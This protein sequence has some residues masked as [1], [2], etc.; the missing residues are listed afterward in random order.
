MDS[1]RRR[2]RRLSVKRKLTAIGVISSMTSLVFAC[3][4]LVLVDV[5]LERARVMRDITTITDV[6]AM[7]SAAAIAFADAEAATGTLSALRVNPHVVAAALRLPDGRVVGR[8]ARGSSVEP[9]SLLGTLHLSRPVVFR[10]ETVGT[11]AVEADY[12]E[13]QGRIE[14]YL[15]I[16][17]VASVGAFLIAVTLSSRLQGLISTPLAD[18]TAAARRVIADRKYDGRVTQTSHDE[19]GELISGFNEML[20]EIQTRDRKLLHHQAELER[21]VE[22]RTAELRATNSD[23]AAARDRAMEASRAKSEFLANMSHEIRTPM[24]GIIGM[25]ELAL[26]TDLSTQQRDYLTTVK[27]SAGSLLTIL[28]DILD[29][30][31]SESQKLELEAIPFSLRDVVGRMLTPIAARADQKGLE[32]LCDINAN[33]PEAVVGDPIR[34]QQILGNLLG[35]AVK[36]TDRGYIVLEVRQDARIDGRSLLHFSITDTGIGI[37]ADKHGLI[38]EPF[39]QADGSTTRR[40]GGTGLGLTISATLVRKMAGQIWVE[41]TPGEGSTFHFT[42]D[43]E[44]AAPALPN[45]LPEPLLADLRVLIVDD[46]PVNRKILLGQFGRWHTR[47]V[48]VASGYEALTA[49]ARAVR[50]ADPFRLV[51]LDVNMPGLDGFDVAERVQSMPELGSPSIV[52]LSSSGQHG[53]S[54]RC[55]ELGIAAYL[56]KPVQSAEL[57]DAICRVLSHPMT[58]CDAPPSTPRA[59]ERA[60]LP[61]RVLLVEDNLINQ[62]VAVGLLARRGHQAIVAENGVHALA[63]LER[64]SFDVILMDLQMPEMGGIEA[65]RLIRAREATTGSRTRIVAMT[66]HAMSGDRERCLAAGMDGYISKPIEPDEFYATLEQPV[67]LKVADRIPADIPS[68]SFDLAGFKKRLGDDLDLVRRVLDAVVED[69]PPQLL[70]LQAAVTNRDAAAIRAAAHALKGAAGNLSATRLFEA[71]KAMEQCG[72]DA[73]LAEADA[74]WQRVSAEAELVLEAVRAA[75]SAALT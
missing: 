10:G 6:A 61:L 11:I 37:P 57:H 17:G 70:A 47:P 59:V 54:P 60:A 41:S 2:L 40:F 3:I 4:V 67:P 52:M 20:D 43:F 64:D 44:I 68:A 53:D 62:Q 24:N 56:T 55:H 32:V 75:Q 69:C 26:D 23:L 25:T 5:S 33:V 8:Y 49:L 27:A 36:F 31:K 42:A 28:N 65:T 45:P 74:A 14:Q 34:L 48:A 21:T 46:N 38:F 19:I 73:R 71:L 66:A 7:N 39:S 13:V 50:G 18:L 29:F 35:N 63:E 9:A 16:L 15:G 51:V 58:A 1:L 12:D 72:T 30:S 22:L